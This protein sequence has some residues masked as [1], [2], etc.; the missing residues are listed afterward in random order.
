MLL[1]KAVYRLYADSCGF[2]PRKPKFDFKTFKWPIG[3]PKRTEM[4]PKTSRG[5]LYGLEAVRIYQD[6]LQVGRGT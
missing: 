5:S 3:M 6:P 2:E 4:S 1:V